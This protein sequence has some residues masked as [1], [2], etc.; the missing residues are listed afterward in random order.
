MKKILAVLAV[1]LAITSFAAVGCD[2]KP[3]TKAQQPSSPK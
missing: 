1:A 2:S 3:S